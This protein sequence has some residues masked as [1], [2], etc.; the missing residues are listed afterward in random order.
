MRF[1]E[2]LGLALYLVMFINCAFYFTTWKY[3]EGDWFGILNTLKLEFS[4]EEYDKAF[5]KEI[6]NAFI[7]KH[8]DFFVDPD[9]VA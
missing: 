3:H 8:P 4:A 6:H 9:L 1:F 5:P 7:I 2:V